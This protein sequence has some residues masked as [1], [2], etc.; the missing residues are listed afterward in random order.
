[1]LRFYWALDDK[2]E[3]DTD[4]RDRISALMVECEAASA[5]TCEMCGLPG[6]LGDDSGWRRVRCAACENKKWPDFEDAA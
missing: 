5:E 3:S 6:K 4:L 2:S 1:V